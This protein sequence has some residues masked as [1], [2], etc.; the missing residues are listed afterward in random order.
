MTHSKHSLLA[1][2][3]IT[4]VACGTDTGG[5]TQNLDCAPTTCA[6]ENKNCGDMPD[7]CGGVINCGSCIAPN[8]CGGG[9]VANVC[10]QGAQCARVSCEHAGAEC[11]VVSNGCD[12]IDRCAK[13][14][15]RQ[16][17]NLNNTCVAV[18]SSDIDA[19]VS[20]PDAG[21][22]GRCDAACM[23]QPGAVC[24]MQ[25]G[26]GGAS[27]RCTPRCGDGYQWDCEVRCCFSYDSFTCEGE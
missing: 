25:C 12:G 27:V 8:A 10:G 19:G 1:A 26:C 17:C 7:G 14:A 6:A 15:P 22:A 16:E 20:L 24:C 21:E 3:A 13:C 18:D 4:A 5:S 2:L 9:N 11:G 23:A